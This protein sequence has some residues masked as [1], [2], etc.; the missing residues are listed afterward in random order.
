M[1]KDQLELIEIHIPSYH[2]LT[3]AEAFMAFHEANPHVYDNLRRLAL[4]ARR[5]RP[6]EQIGMKHLF[7]VLRWE[8]KIKTERP[9]KEF[10]LNNNFTASYA[11]ALMI[12]EPKLAGAFETRVQRTREP[13]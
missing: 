6:H 10:R 1:K 8:Y 11:R 9:E 3:Q 12:G 5:R 2:G 7:E 4:E 13:V